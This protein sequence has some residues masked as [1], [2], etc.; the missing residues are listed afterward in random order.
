MRYQFVLQFLGDSV[1]DYDVL[2]LLEERLIAVLGDTAEVD[3]HDIGSGETNDFVLTDD[4][5]SS[6]GRVAPILDEYAGPRT[7]R[8]AFRQVAGGGYTVLWPQGFRGR[9]SVA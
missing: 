8:V 2:V 5:R 6:M 7:M 9:F 3:G 4:P 1:A